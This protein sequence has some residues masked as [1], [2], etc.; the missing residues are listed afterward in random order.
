[1]KLIKSSLAFGFL[2]FTQI[3]LSC[4]ESV[5]VSDVKIKISTTPF[6]FPVYELE[7]IRF[8]SKTLGRKQEILIFRPKNIT[9]KDSIRILYLLDGDLSSERLQT[10]RMRF[11]GF[12]S[13]FITVG[14]SNSKSKNDNPY[15]IDAPRYL[16]F[17]TNEVIPR[18]EKDYTRV[19][20]ILYGHSNAGTFTIYS[21]LNKPNYF[22]TYYAIDPGNFTGLTKDLKEIDASSIQKA[23]LNLS[24]NMAD[25]AKGQEELKYLKNFLIEKGNIALHW[26]LELFSKTSFLD[27]VVKIK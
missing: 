17:L 11:I 2:L 16:S 5:R 25:S 8:K 9:V 26:N 18:V 22:S 21:L 23:K 27:E 19:M 10:L 14:I 4:S 3:F 13:E 20:R 12:D 7:Q 24:Y 1:M 6:P 15:T